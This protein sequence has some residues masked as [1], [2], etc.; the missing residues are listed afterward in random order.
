LRLLLNCREDL[1][2]ALDLAFGLG[3]MFFKGSL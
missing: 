3:A 1:F 2:Q